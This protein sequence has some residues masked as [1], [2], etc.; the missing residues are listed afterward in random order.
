MVA[1]FSKLLAHPD[2][3]EIISKIITGQVPKNIA[4]WLKL[5][6]PGKD[7]GHLR[8]PMALLKE[9]VDKGAL[10]MAAQFQADLNGVVSGK[11]MSAS[12]KNNKTYQERLVELADKEIDIKTMIT[13]TLLMIRARAEQVFDIIQ[14]NPRSWKPDYVMIKYFEILFNSIEKCDKIINN[15]PD[16]VVQHNIT[17]QVM[18]SNIAIFQEAIRETA[19]EIDPEI[20]FIFI[21]KL[22]AKMK[23]L[24]EPAPNFI[25]QDK[26]LVEA[27]VLNTTIL[28]QE[29]KN[30]LSGE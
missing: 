6:Y 12:L 18:E 7:Q 17:M 11:E 3:D 1:D 23:S 21:D 24:Q 13:E 28:N 20:A 16:Q 5:K 9:F 10:D 4:D 30:E 19:A 22:T 2:K 15:K 27:Q 8:L 14:E 26:R 29:A 25:T